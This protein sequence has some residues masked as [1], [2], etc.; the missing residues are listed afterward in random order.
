MAIF[1]AFRIPEV[2]CYDGDE[3]RIYLLQADGTFAPSD[4]SLAFPTIPVQELTRFIPPV[5]NLD[6]LGAVN[7]VRMRW[8]RSWRGGMR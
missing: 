2:W 1:A 4:V 8:G 7:S 3:L 6:Y 5:G